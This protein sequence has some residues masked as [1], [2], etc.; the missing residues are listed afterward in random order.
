MCVHLGHQWVPVCA[1]VINTLD[2][3]PKHFPHACL[4]QPPTPRVPLGLIKDLVYLDTLPLFSTRTC[5]Q[6]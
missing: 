6:H 3:H 5:R 2:V 1:Y 4:P